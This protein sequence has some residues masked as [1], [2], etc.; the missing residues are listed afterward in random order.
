[1]KKT[2]AIVFILCL[3]AGLFAMVTQFAYAEEVSPITYEEI[4]Q[5]IANREYDCYTDSDS[6]YDY[7]FLY[8]Y[9][10]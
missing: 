2:L 6:L 9:L 3:T 5:K 4:Q 8:I 10:G 7:G 1:M